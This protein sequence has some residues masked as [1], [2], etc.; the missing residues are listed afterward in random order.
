[1][2]KSPFLFYGSAGT[3]IDENLILKQGKM[4]SFAAD[5]KG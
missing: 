5:S 1:V 3:G 2:P 4:D